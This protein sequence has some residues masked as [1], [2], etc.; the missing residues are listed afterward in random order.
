[1]HRW[2]W[3]RFEAM[4]KRHLMRK[5]REELRQMRDLRLAALDANTNFDAEDNIKA[6]EDRTNA[7]QQAYLDGVKMIYSDSSERPVDP[8]EDDPLFAPIRKRANVLH[9]EINQPLVEQAGVGRELLEA[10]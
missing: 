3:R 10:T 9:Q 6:K 7:L 8:F 1:M 4:F 2:P 5:A